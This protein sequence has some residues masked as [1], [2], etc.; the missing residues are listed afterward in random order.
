MAIQE[1]ERIRMPD[2]ETFFRQYICTRTPVIITD[3]F[4]GQP[5]REIRTLSDA[6]RAFGG[7]KLKVQTEYA[8]AATT[9]SNVEQSVTFNEYW[10]FVRAN[11]STD[12]LCTEHEI[13]ARVLALFDLPSACRARDVSEQEVLGMPRTFGDHDLLSNVFIANRGNRAHL[14]YDGD[15]RQVIL[16]QV[17]GR[18]EVF[19]FQPTSGINLKALDGGCG[20]SGVFLEHLS[21]QEK[22]ELA[23]RANG[24]HA[25]IHPG[26]AIYMP[27]LIWHYLEYVDDSM[28]F[29]IR[30]GRNRLGRFFCIDNFHRDYYI[31]NFAAKLADRARCETQYRDELADVIAAYRKPASSMREKVAA[32]R[33][34]FRGLCERTCAESQPQEYCPTE[35]ESAEIDKIVADIGH[36]LRYADPAAAAVMRPTGPMS[37]TQRRQLEETAVLRGYT[38]QVLQ[39]LLF[40]RVGKRA[41]DQL[42]KAEAAQFMAYMRAPGAAW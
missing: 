15:H 4:A 40:N 2:N 35:R 24:Y 26:D 6:Q 28:S 32:M 7:V 36:T 34:H 22:L 31:Q 9:R 41:V 10:N 23:D 30:F 18:K 16:Y 19:L 5:I 33:T 8:A 38:P 1:I 3:L 20:F 13:P 14:H 21:A 27:M 29:N 39:R 11:P 12:M 37:P 42:T 25:T 17:F